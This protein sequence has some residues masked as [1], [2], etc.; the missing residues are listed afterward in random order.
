[1][2]LQVLLKILF[3]AA[4]DCKNLILQGCFHI[5]SLAKTVFWMYTGQ[6]IFKENFMPVFNSGALVLYHNK[7]AVVSAVAKDKIEI[8]I[9]GGAHK[10]VRSKDIEFLHSG[11]VATLPPTIL[12]TPELTEIV[13]LMENE[14]FS[15]AAF[16]ELLYSKRSAEAF[17][18]AWLLLADGIYF[19]GSAVNGV[20]VRP[21]AE[22]AAALEAA[23]LKDEKALR[24]AELIGR[25][26]ADELCREDYSAMRE[27][28]QVARGENASSRLLK[29]LEIEAT[30]QKAHALLLKLGVWD[31]FV[32]PHPAR[33]GVE[34]T[35]PA[36]P[37]PPLSPEERLDLTGMVSYAIDDEGNEDPDDAVGFAEGLLWV[38]VADPAAVVTP[39][40]EPDMGARSRGENLYLPEKVMH[41]LPAEA[42][43]IFG[44]GLREIS[45]AFSFAIRIDEEGEP[46]LEKMVLSTVKVTRLT[47]AGAAA[48]WEESPLV[49]LRP[50]LERFRKKRKAAGALMI[51]LPEVKIRV[52]EQNVEITPVEITPERELVANAMLAC[53]AAVARYAV[54]NEIRLPFATQSCL[55][56][57][58]AEAVTLPEM[59]TLRKSCPPSVVQTVA[60][61]HA[62][63][64]LNAYCRVTS[65]LRRYSDLLA[66]QQLRRVIKG[67]A[68]LSM[69]ELDTRIAMA[70]KNALVRRR[71]ER[72]CNEFWTQVFFVLHPDWTGEAVLV[73]KQGDRLTYLIPEL[74]YEFKNRYSGKAVLGERVTAQL[75]RVGTTAGI[76]TFCLNGQ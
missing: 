38:H 57:E 52:K 16:A 33:A 12:S 69:D 60:A 8:R 18:S 14:T 36:F 51:D 17:Y 55:E 64:G 30:P 20:R 44:L 58:S 63:L 35:D 53:G 50:M 3:V 76:A 19:T 21:A 40:S 1:L 28:E 54:E 22:I 42:T 43:R 39:G 67:E 41:M 10:S 34:L 37:L 5:Q 72:T 31:S 7:S 73:Q 68:P 75:V 26:K 15:F 45:P 74:A 71:L 46:V 2:I 65:P 23:R 49:E 9:E 61:P 48:H 59:F 11:P 70:E 6:F 4:N 13:E 56:T 47:Y 66:H 25:I 29:E 32:N 24:R 62:G 27:I